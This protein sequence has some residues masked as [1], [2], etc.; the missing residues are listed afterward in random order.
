MPP[1]V[2]RMKPKPRQYTHTLMRVGRVIGRNA[3]RLKNKRARRELPIAH[4]HR[5]FRSF[6]RPPKMSCGA[7]NLGS[8]QFLLVSHHSTS[9][10]IHHIQLIIHRQQH[11]RRWLDQLSFPYRPPSLLYLSASQPL[12]SNYFTNN[13]AMP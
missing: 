9:R 1:R 12:T 8:C 10:L 11:L 4:N 3:S 6:P 2:T 7:D 5:P 13:T